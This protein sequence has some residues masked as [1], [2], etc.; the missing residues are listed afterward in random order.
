MWETC[1]IIVYVST[2]VTPASG[3]YTAHRAVLLT[4]CSGQSLYHPRPHYSSNTVIVALLLLLSGVEQNPGPSALTHRNNII[5]GSLNVHTAENKILLIHQ[6]IDDHNLDILAMN[7]TWLRENTPVTI[8]RDL[9][10]P[11]YS[12]QHIHHVHCPGVKGSVGGGGL[13]IIHRREISVKQ[14]SGQET[15]MVGPTSSN[16]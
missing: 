8:K 12:V 5:F 11:G 16:L 14:H 9:A 13:A 4:P 7:E 15:F 3:L 2:V 6:I 10:P 1:L